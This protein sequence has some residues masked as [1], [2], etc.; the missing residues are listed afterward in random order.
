MALNRALFAAD[1]LRTD[2]KL[3]S[4]ERV[5]ARMAKKCTT[6]CAHMNFHY[7]SL[8]VLLALAAC[9]GSD[10]SPQN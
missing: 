1:L 8:A 6:L 3:P 10:S 5:R 2:R 9:N 7:L 4:L